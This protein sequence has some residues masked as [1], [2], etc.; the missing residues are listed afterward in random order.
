MKQKWLSGPYLLWMALFILIPMLL[1]GY[2][3]F[4][5]DMNG[6]INIAREVRAIANGIHTAVRDLV[7]AP[8]FA[9]EDGSAL[10]VTL[11]GYQSNAIAI[12]DTLAGRET[13]DENRVAAEEILAILDDF[14]VIIVPI[15]NVDYISQDQLTRTLTAVDELRIM[16]DI[17]PQTAADATGVVFNVDGFRDAVTPDF[18]HVL[19]RSV[20][21]AAV[22]TLICFLIG[23]PV[24]Y[25]LASKDFSMKTTLILLF[26]LPMWMNHLLRTYAWLTILE[27]NGVLNNVLNAMGL[28][29][30]DIL[31]THAAVILGMVYNFLPFMILPIRTSLGKIDH[32]LI[33]AAQDLG[34]GPFTVLRRV[35]LPLSVPGIISGITMVFMPAAT[36]FI[37]P[38]FLGGGQYRMI[39]NVIESQFIDGNNWNFGAA[40]SLVLMVVVLLSMLLVNRVDKDDNVGTL[41]K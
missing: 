27:R 13:I 38:Q 33:E 26:A 4:T 3:A 5:R 2:N 14:L 36:T 29:G 22:S 1:V 15:L 9:T 25:I 30:I 10:R 35:V 6:R 20:W 7:S 17:L 32:S 11:L 37:I 23:Y 16:G 18:L 41:M 21:V 24:A 19:W 12:R 34:G 8:F 40:L 39:G 31:Y 28:P